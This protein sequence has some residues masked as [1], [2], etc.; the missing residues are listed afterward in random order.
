M[1]KSSS[2]MLTAAL[3]FF[4]GCNQGTPG[5]KTTVPDTTTTRINANGMNETTTTTTT[6]NSTDPN[7]GSHSVSKPLVGENDGTFTLD[8]PNLGA[9]IKQGEKQNITIGI[10]RGDNFDQDVTLHLTN[11]PQG[12]TATPAEPVLKK[13]EEEVVMSVAVAADAALGDFTVNV[14]GSPSGSGASA[15]NTLQLTV[16]EQ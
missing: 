4:S 14:S 9:S 6:G 13:G 11:V 16:K 15:T 8:M 7:V 2:A 12:V 10:N 1:N 3:V 5:G